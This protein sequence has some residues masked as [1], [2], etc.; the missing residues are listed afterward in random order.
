MMTRKKF[1]YNS[2]KCTSLSKMIRLTSVL[3][4]T[5]LRTAKLL[6]RRLGYTFDPHEFSAGLTAELEH[7]DVT[8]GDL[9]ATAKIAAAHLKE[10][11]KYYSL[12]K[13]YVE[14]NS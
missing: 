3:I 5:K 7:R 10:N 1:N 2:V 12:L 4:E 8:D 11:P 14:P 9:I 6:M 13:K